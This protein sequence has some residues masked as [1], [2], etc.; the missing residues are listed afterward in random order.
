MDVIGKNIWMDNEIQKHINNSFLFKLILK[1]IWIKRIKEKVELKNFRLVDRMLYFYK[2]I[3]KLKL[4]LFRWGYNVLKICKSDKEFV[5]YVN[6]NDLVKDIRNWKIMFSGIL[7]DINSEKDSSRYVWIVI[8]TENYPMN[9]R[10]NNILSKNNY[11]DI[12]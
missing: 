5:D 3:D 4:Y 7:W 9:S 11:P 8:V 12:F 6:E 2:S 1:K 10:V